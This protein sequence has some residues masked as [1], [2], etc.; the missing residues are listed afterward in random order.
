MRVK[1]EWGFVHV[2]MRN[3]MSVAVSSKDDY[4]WVNEKEKE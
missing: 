2:S 3:A 1:G 4:R